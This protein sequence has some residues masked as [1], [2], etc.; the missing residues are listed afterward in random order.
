MTAVTVCLLTACASMP[1]LDNHPRYA[2]L[3]SVRSLNNIP[4][5]PQIEDQ[6]G[7]ASLATILGVQGVNVTPEQLRGKLYIPGKEGAVTT[8]MLAR[9]RRYGLL[10]YVLK[11][12]LVDVLAEVDAGNPVLVM[13][14]LGLD[15]LPRWHFSVA[16]AYDL[17]TQTISLRSGDKLQHEIGFGLFLK[18]WRRAGFWSMVAV[19][20][21]TL[22]VTADPSGVT[23]A[24]NDLEQVG[25]TAAAFA[26][27]QSVLN[28]WPGSG[29]ANFG[30]GNSAYALGRYAE[31]QYFFSSYLKWYPNAPE[32]WNNM[33]Y[34]LIKLDCG[35]EALQAISCAVK[36]A[37]NNPVFTESYNDISNG[38]IV[39][40]RLF[41]CPEIECPAG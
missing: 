24:A 39:V 18:T 26:V 2:Q 17:N 6:C 5:F 37:P 7:P 41:S 1:D 22:P 34:N 30:A 12:E 10:A 38:E 14:N 29:A 15:W 27:Y 4:Y 16:V 23:Q 35:P 31:A 33:A 13:Q 9:A 32:G 8:E 19:P 20:A 11:P 28:R 3:T 25:E 40:E 21:G 36:F